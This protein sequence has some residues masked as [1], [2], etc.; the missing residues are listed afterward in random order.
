MKKTFLL[1]PLA[2]IL[3]MSLFLVSCEDEPELKTYTVTFLLDE[4]DAEPFDKKTVLEGAGITDAKVPEKTGHKFLYWKTAGGNEAYE[5]KTPVKGDLTLVAVWETNKYT[6][7]FMDGETKAAD[8]QTVEYGKKATAPEVSPK[9]GHTLS[10]KKVGSSSPFDFET[11]V[12]TEDTVLEA[13]WD[14]N[15]Y[16]VTFKNYDDTEYATKDVFYN[17]KVDKPEG[18]PTRGEGYLFKYWTL[19]NTVE[20]QKAYS[21]DTPVEGNLVLYPVFI[22]TF[23]V[24]FDCGKGVENVP[25]VQTVEYGKNATKPSDPTRTGYIFEYWTLD[26][27][28]EGQKKEYSFDT[29]VVGNLVL[30]PVFEKIK[31]TITFVGAEGISS[32]PEQQEVEYGST[33]VY[34]ANPTKAGFDFAGWKEKDKDVYIYSSTVIDRNME[35]EACWNKKGLLK[36]DENGNVN[37]NTT[38]ENDSNVTVIVIPEK[39]GEYI[40]KKITKDAFTQWDNI[41]KV[42]LPPTI[43]TIEGSSGTQTPGGAFYH[44]SSLTSI[45]IPSSVEKIG[46]YA[47]ADSGL[48]SV[49]INSSDT[50]LIIDQRAFFNCNLS[51]GVEFGGRRIYLCNEA[52][53]YSKGLTSVTIKG[54]FHDGTDQ[55]KG[56][57]A[58]KRVEIIEDKDNK[59]IPQ[60]MFYGCTSLSEVIL[61]DSLTKIWSHAFEGCRNLQ[62]ITLPNKVERI[63]SDAFA[64]TGLTSITIPSSVKTIDFNPFSSCTYLKSI[65]VDSDN[66][67]YKNDDN[68]VLFKKDGKTI[69]S[70]P[71]GKSNESYTIPDG[72]T[73]IVSYAF[74]GCSNLKTINLN[75]VTN[76]EH[77]AFN[78]SGLASIIIPSS[79][80]TIGVDAFKNCANLSEINI[81]KTEGDITGAPWGAPN[82]TKDQVQ[83]K[84]VE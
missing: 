59:H 61:P 45:T 16:T 7:S 84:I 3:V 54:Y 33:F 72:V 26:N 10:W 28:V 20:G 32:V 55:F 66:T 8:P 18:A 41:T 63:F 44:C 38:Y 62:S 70:Y 31:V 73:T 25:K 47:F 29:P 81:Q 83:W 4:G 50:G 14:I 39:I 17:G 46:I 74:G 37:G 56:C 12:I 69:V 34:P 48:N 57:I 58:L 79:V 49:T 51:K 13:V 82:V 40:P 27:A 30:Y 65:S 1:V 22:E 6:V 43:E 21:F 11:E 9:D 23:T 52:F 76:I 67:A 78:G 60:N 24:S 2:I 15:T 64:G 80:T 77:N 75:Q 5:L 35:L 68:G 71:A 42:V 36:I 53:A 19:D